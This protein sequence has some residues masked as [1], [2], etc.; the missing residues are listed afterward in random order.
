LLT[1]ASAVRSVGVKKGTQGTV[2]VHKRLFRHDDCSVVGRTTKSTS[3]LGVFSEIG[4]RKSRVS[5]VILVLVLA[6]NGRRMVGA[7][8]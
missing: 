8:D 4:D 7:I 6:W 3:F 1:T 5:K 2:I